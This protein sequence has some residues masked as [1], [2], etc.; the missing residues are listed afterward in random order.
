VFI[1]TGAVKPGSLVALMGGSGAGKST[2]MAALAYR[3]P[4]T[5]THIMAKLLDYNHLSIKLSVLAMFQ[6]VWLLTEI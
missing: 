3:N 1:V 5:N 2:L 6:L 4:G